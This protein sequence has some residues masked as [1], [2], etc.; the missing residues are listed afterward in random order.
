[1]HYKNL[2]PRNTGLYKILKKI[3]SN[4]YVLDLPS[5]SGV[6]S[7]FN[8]EDLTPYRGHNNDGETEEQATALP[9]NLQ[10][11]DEIVDVLD[12]QLISTHQG[13]FQKFYVRW[14]K[15]PLSDATWI[16]AIDFQRL[17]PDLY[18][19]NQAFNSP[20]SSSFKPGRVDV[21]RSRSKTRAVYKT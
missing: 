21:A 9:S 3:G 15:C 18:E 20:E 7:T 10:P 17:N 16:A 19:R 13:G 1:M 11:I 12:D 8:V 5:D 14:K 4:A 2:H 6:S